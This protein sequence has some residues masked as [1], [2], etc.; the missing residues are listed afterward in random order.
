MKI[1]FFFLFL[2]HLPQCLAFM[3]QVNKFSE[4]SHWRILNP[5]QVSKTAEYKSGVTYPRL[6]Q[7]NSCLSYDSS[8]SCIECYEEIAIQANITRSKSYNSTNTQ[9]NSCN[10]EINSNVTISSSCSQ[11]NE[12]ISVK[13]TIPRK[14][15][16]TCCYKDYNNDATLNFT[17]NSSCNQCENNSTING[18]CCYGQF[19]NN[20]TG[21]CES[22]PNECPN[23]NSTTGECIKNST[24]LCGDLCDDC[25]ES[26]G[27][28]QSCI[29]D[30]KM[31]SSG[32]NCVCNDGY[33]L[34]NTVC[35]GCGN[36]CSV[37]DIG[38]KN[39][40]C[41]D[42]KFYNK[43]SEACESC[44]N[45]CLSCKEQLAI[46][47]EIKIKNPVC[48]ANG[49]YLNSSSVCDKCPNNC[50]LC[51]K[52]TGVCQ[53]CKEDL[54]I[55]GTIPIKNSTCCSD[56]SY[57]KGSFCEPCPNNCRNCN[58]TTGEC[59]E[60][61]CGSLCADCDKELGLCR[62]CI[63]EIKMQVFG[64]NCICGEGY[65]LSD[66]IC[67]GCGN[68]CSLCDINGK[69]MTCCDGKFYN[70]TS[71]A[72]ESCPNSCLSCNITGTCS[73][74]DEVLTVSGEIQIKNPMC[75]ADGFYLN[76]SSVCDKCPN[77]CI[78]C[79]K[80]TG[81]CQDCEDDLSII[82]TISIKNS[83][84]CSDGNYL[85]GSFCEP[86]PNNCK[87]CN[88][89]TGECIENKCGSL[90]TDCDKDQGLCRRCIGEI[91]M[92]VFGNNCICSEGYFLNDAI[93]QGC[94]NNCSLCDINGK[95]MTCCDG[96]F[97]NKTSNACESCPNNCLSC[98]ITGTCSNCDE[99]LTVSG[100]IQIKNPMCCAD[101]FYL[102]SSS[103]CDKCPNNCILCD[104]TTGVCQD[105]EDDLSIIGAIS[106]KNSTCCS[107]GNYLNGSFCEP[108]PNNCKNCNK[109]TGEC[110]ENK[111]GSLCTDCDKELGLCRRCI[112]E[113][114]MQVFG[115]N[116]IC[117]EG[118]FLN[119]A[120]CQGCGN[121][122]SLCD[123]NGKN[124]TCCDGKFYNKTS[125]A[126][127]S[128]P[129]SCLS[130]N[131]T[132]TCSNCDEVLTVSGEIQIKNP[133][134][135]ADGFY[136]NSSSVC[137]KCPNNCILCDKT[138][139]VCQD[140]EDD[141]SIIGTISIKN[142]ACCSDGNYLNGSS[143]EPCPNNCKNCNKTTGECIE[144]KCGSLCADCDKELELCRRCIDEI[145]M[146]V[147]GNNCICS[148]GYFLKENNACQGCGN[149]CSVC[150]ING[151]NTTCCDGKFYNN[152]SC[153]PCPT[154]CCNK[155]EGCEN[156]DEELT[157]SGEI[158]PKSPT[159]CSD[160]FYFN[161]LT[162]LCE[163]CPNGCILCDKTTGICNDCT[164]D[165]N[166]S[167]T[168]P[169]KN[170]TCCDDGSYLNGSSC[171]SCHTNCNY[172][173]KQTGDCIT[174][175]DRM[176]K[177]LNDPKICTC[178]GNQTYESVCVCPSGTYFDSSNCV[179]CSDLCSKCDEFTGECQGCVDPKMEID[180]FNKKTCRCIGDQ[181]YINGQCT[182]PSGKQ[183]NGIECSPCGTFCTSCD[184]V[185]NTCN[186]CINERMKP[187]SNSITCQCKGNQI[188]TVDNCICPAG[189]YFDTLN[190]LP[191]GSLCAE[192][193]DLTWICSKCQ[194]NITME[195]SSDNLKTCKCRGSQ[196]YDSVSRSC[197]C[198]KGYFDNST[199]QDC[200]NLC[201]TCDETKCLLCES[202]EHL[203][204]DLSSPK[205]CHC[206]NG[207]NWIS[208]ENSCQKC[209]LG[210]Y[211]DGYKCNNCP[212]NC[213]NCT[214][215]ACL[216]NPTNLCG[217]LCSDCNNQSGLC[218][219]C[220]D[221]TSMDIYE[222]DCK[223][224]AGYFL[225]N[226]LKCK[227]C[228]T[229]C[230]ACNKNSCEICDGP[231]RMTIDPENNLNCSCIGNQTLADGQ[232]KCGEDEWFNS[233]T[234]QKC[235]FLCEKCEN[236]TGNCISCKGGIEMEIKKDNKTC[237]CKNA[238]D[239]WN[240]TS[241]IACGHWCSQCDDFSGKCSNCKNPSTMEPDTTSCKCKGMLI[242]DKT[243]S[244]CICADRYYKSGTNCIS[245]SDSNCQVCT[246]PGQCS[247]CSDI[248]LW[249]DNGMCKAC[250]PGKVSNKN[251]FSCNDCSVNY[252]YCK[253]IAGC[254]C[255]NCPCSSGY[256]SNNLQ[257]Y[258]CNSKCSDENCDTCTGP[259]QCC[260]CKKLTDY[261]DGY[262][263]KSCP[264][265]KKS[266]NDGRT[267]DNCQ[268]S[269]YAEDGSVSCKDS[270]AYPLCEMCIKK[271]DCKDCGDI[272]INED[273]LCFKISLPEEKF[274]I[275]DWSKNF[276][277][278]SNC[279]S[280]FSRKLSNDENHRGLSMPDISK[281]I[282]NNSEN[283]D[284]EFEW[285]YGSDSS[286]FR[287]K[288]SP[289]FN[290]QS[291][292]SFSL[293]I[294]D[295][296][297]KWSI[298]PTSD[299][300]SKKI[301]E[302]SLEWVHIIYGKFGKFSVNISNIV[303]NPILSSCN[304]IFDDLTLSEIGGAMVSCSIDK[305]TYQ[306]LE[307]I[308]D[309]SK[310]L[311][312][313][314]TFKNNVFLENL[315]DTS[316]NLRYL[317][318]DVPSPER[319]TAKIKAPGEICCGCNLK[320]D[321][322][323]SVV[324]GDKTTYLWTI[325]QKYQQQLKGAVVNIQA[326]CSGGNLDYNIELS[327]TDAWSHTSE[328]SDRWTVKTSQNK[329]TVEL[330]TPSIIYVNKTADFS[331]N[332]YFSAENSKIVPD[333]TWNYYPKS[334][335]A[336][337]KLITGQ[338][339]IS[340][341]FNEEGDYNIIVAINPNDPNYQVQTLEKQITAKLDL[342][343]I[344]VQG[345]NTTI[346]AKRKFPFYAK[347]LYSDG[348]SDKKYSL[349]LK[350]IFCA[351]GTVTRNISNNGEFFYQPKVNDDF[352]CN[353][354]IWANPNSTTS[355]GIIE[356][357]CYFKVTKVEVPEVSVSYPPEFYDW[358][359]WIRFTP[360]M[361][362]QEGLE[363]KW[364]QKLPKDNIIST[365]TPTNQCSYS[366][367]PFVLTPGVRYSFAIQVTNISDSDKN[368]EIET[369][370][371]VNCPPQN[372]T[373][374]V[375]PS[376]GIALKDQFQIEFNSWRDL[377]NNTPFYYQVLQV[378]NDGVVAIT[379][380]TTQNNFNITL[381][382]EGKVKLL[383]RV[384]DSRGTFQN[385]S[386]TITVNP[387]Q[388]NSNLLGEA[389]ALKKESLKLGG[390]VFVSKMV[391][392]VQ[393][394]YSNETDQNSTQEVMSTLIGAFNEWTDKDEMS[395]SEVNTAVDVLRVF[396]NKSES[397]NTNL[398]EDITGSLKNV[399]SK[400]TKID[401]GTLT[402]GIKVIGII[403][404]RT[405][406]LS[407]SG[408]SN[409]TSA[410]T[411]IQAQDIVKN[412]T[413][414]YQ[415]DT[416]ANEPPYDIPGDYMNITLITLPKNKTFEPKI[417]W[418][419]N[420]TVQISVDTKHDNDDSRYF[421]YVL[422][423]ASLNRSESFVQKSNEELSSPDSCS[424]SD[425][426]VLSCSIL[427]VKNTYN[428]SEPN[429]PQYIKT[430]IAKSSD[431][432][433]N[434][435]VK[436]VE[437]SYVMTTMISPFGDGDFIECATLN[438]NNG[439]FI[440]IKCKTKV[441]KDRSVQC[442]CEA[443]DLLTLSYIPNI[444]KEVVKRQIPSIKPDI[445][446]GLAWI[447]ITVYL[448]N[449]VIY[450]I[451]FIDMRKLDK[452]TNKFLKRKISYVLKET[453]QDIKDIAASNQ[454][455]E[456]EEFIELLKENY[457]NQIKRLESILSAKLLDKEE[458]NWMPDLMVKNRILKQFKD[459]WKKNQFKLI[460]ANIQEL[461]DKKDLHF[462]E[463]INKIKSRGSC[464]K[465]WYFIRGI[466][467]SDHTK[468]EI[469]AA[470]EN[471]CSYKF[472]KI[473]KKLYKRIMK[474]VANIDTENL[475][476][477][478]VI[479][480]KYNPPEPENIHIKIFDYDTN[481]YANLMDFLNKNITHNLDGKNDFYHKFI[482]ENLILGLVGYTDLNFTRTARFTLLMVNV[483]M[484]CW[485][486][487]S[488][489]QADGWFYTTE[490]EDYGVNLVK[491][492]I[493]AISMAIG[494]IVDII[495]HFLPNNYLQEENLSN[496]K[497]VS[498]RSKIAYIF[499]W[500]LMVYLAYSACLNGSKL[501]SDQQIQL[502]QAI[503]I[504]LLSNLTFLGLIKPGIIAAFQSEAV[505]QK[506]SGIK[507]ILCFCKRKGPGIAPLESSETERFT[508]DNNV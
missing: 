182:C 485:V 391:A 429:N 150:E 116:C 272:D 260:K 60:L 12:Q 314:L 409:K 79:D 319:P 413:E 173:D 54:R 199:C 158:K 475:N 87:N 174:C 76:S 468:L 301:S 165:I 86:C 273:F 47:G 371:L 346:N 221:E 359:D 162:S 238:G 507:K 460:K 427:E 6:L 258:D 446:L 102:N 411:Y 360:S 332:Y 110:I 474:L 349:Y 237:K 281:I 323:E 100:E 233:S 345:V 457:D 306:T 357:A 159:C 410:E 40:M 481:S 336:N 242:P 172:C 268:I 307:V 140:C 286:I 341:I 187:I 283:G 35:K 381:G 32:S 400:A 217:S 163:K 418:S 130:C 95:N 84:C 145:K 239:F 330:I 312:P 487:I 373:F 97:Y 303:L 103:V 112:D 160:G 482:K 30:S 463:N 278:T 308:M 17:I 316:G 28:C 254:N 155:T 438:E 402:Q 271:S 14:Q 188:A 15:N 334:N 99:V 232:C 506:F 472:K 276:T 503:F 186:E 212:D 11:C 115:N 126:C 404:N 31:H 385:S 443:S 339:E 202:I 94:G 374:S 390:T 433:Y 491:V 282:K 407:S 180:Q 496:E 403:S 478:R 465:I 262:T 101:G 447:S 296:S 396:V 473:C 133:M 208:S 462:I 498:W 38:G 66:I 129:N 18:I 236:E 464:L 364:V 211:Y 168:I 328:P 322:S 2:L 49:F 504:N 223:C 469:I 372:G 191:C 318:F 220:I 428:Y 331:V 215:S 412:L 74:C 415:V 274:V 229:N 81:V 106:I 149:S 484:N 501:K 227:E 320:L 75:C 252:N 338:K 461:M 417:N 119:D 382:K 50:M 329:Y 358:S 298:T 58:K 350:D 124:T 46:S 190:C 495:G 388:E 231:W 292:L 335:Q 436:P 441:N 293:N 132:G 459:S 377:E 205:T 170:S 83:T 196:Q 151:K 456:Y 138:T 92:Q 218:Q 261:I 235:G 508:H 98:N 24:I 324:Y 395:L 325:K 439:L 161:S 144:N 234:C 355:P 139:G 361:P 52:T 362:K 343:K 20:R 384:Y 13:G 450:V 453:K 452:L 189:Y 476:E 10:N 471:N 207:Y 19:Y 123:I 51:D 305:S 90:C 351:N 448:L 41:C 91:K 304:A 77:N 128:C 488:F 299:S 419:K 178:I 483:F 177:D 406:S 109:T 267:C 376:E 259:E 430:A 265:N 27:L 48:C 209:S 230:S 246:G 21:N 225:D 270:C 171:E 348:S 89:T 214:A 197:Y 444:I 437:V 164:E 127:E 108:C 399:L 416:N 365:S 53:D 204:I 467:I 458:K 166:V 250:P 36:N 63:D 445:Y 247:Y 137:D 486:S 243:D 57:L 479:E 167:G 253:T 39:T 408:E 394:T 289:S 401:Q 398:I 85:N 379:P 477:L 45:S 499:S 183:F 62:Q 425:D 61:K 194:H 264:G 240:G 72:C 353:F 344:V 241:C 1:I 181:I 347:L 136:L 16:T 266:N 201:S 88:K 249:V 363:C 470:I 105:C 120:I 203:E 451:I 466:F 369:T 3:N 193:S 34:D 154:S 9:C 269:V 490:L 118:Y 342:P 489:F 142:S 497:F 442:I 327:V 198:H 284:I 125:A 195:V 279:Q 219:K 431:D 326:D 420:T 505:S 153:E 157:I 206:K 288:P 93:C 423:T 251:G 169:I 502:I 426:I 440:N 22:C 96:K 104:K 114:K 311:P 435:G 26:L 228:G 122:C 185:G 300:F 56:G 421:I 64:N 354:T 213:K 117:S 82:G 121:N 5:S 184:L 33:F 135:C 294:S 68:N 277:V 321:G 392:I 44:P 280:C 340:V 222:N 70:K 480:F 375:T 317:T 7:Q 37:C 422:T 315:N 156:C 67:Q 71:A 143:C 216:D 226:D 107:D 356:T 352:W 131:I 55:S 224:K 147:F 4:I 313:T 302:K 200:G 434:P 310:T 134:C 256:Y 69:N 8:G 309:G 210:T 263:C 175:K 500:S 290:L 255:P 449:T 78:L 383:G 333:V 397:L 113:I 59:I 176:S 23:C 285:N 287:I 141:L 454:D 370:R 146:Q 152:G 493:V 245:C 291:Q 389:N 248:T 43:T 80:T 244:S 386:L 337:K 257:D 414:K 432:F 424:M 366:I 275:G 405:E 295:S 367:E 368:I 179:L 25:N 29:D 148:E 380:K 387:N 492:L 455:I 494:L 192:C 111:C 378:T 73:N 65:S 42:G 393:L 297:Y